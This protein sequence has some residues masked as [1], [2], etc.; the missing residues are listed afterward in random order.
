[1]NDLDIFVQLIEIKD[2]QQQQI[3]LTELVGD[4]AE[5]QKRVL[6]LLQ[7]HVKGGSF[8]ETKDHFKFPVTKPLE[9]GE[10]VGDSVGPYKL[11]EVIGEGGMGTVFVADQHVPISRRVALKIIKSGMDSRSVIARFEAERQALALMDHPN[12]ARVLD[13]GRTASGSPYFC[14]EL[15]KGIAITEY[16]EKFDLSVSDRLRL[17]IPICNAIQHAHQKGII[18][19]D[20]KPSNILVARHDGVAVPKVID[21]GVAKAIGQRLTEGTIYTQFGQIIGTLEYMSPEQAEFNQLDIDTRTDVYSLGVVLYQLLTGVTPIDGK[22]LRSAAFD[23]LLRIIREEVPMRPSWKVTSTLTASK[24]ANGKPIKS[25]HSVS[26]L[27]NELD[28]IIMKTLEKDRSRRYDSPSDLAKDLAN[29]LSG[30]PVNAHPPSRIYQFRKLLNRNKA[31]SLAMS[32]V[33]LSLLGGVLISGRETARAVKAE[34]R[35]RSY[36][37][38]VEYASQE[39]QQQLKIKNA[40]TSFLLDDLL[41]KAATSNQELDKY[42]PTPDL[43]VVEALSR[44]ATHVEARF[45][46]DPKTECEIRRVL[47][48]AFWNIGQYDKSLVQYELAMEIY[49]KLAVKNNTT[50]LQLASALVSSYLRKRDLKKAESMLDRLGVAVEHRDESDTF[51]LEHKMHLAELYLRQGKIV[52]ANNI[53]EKWLAYAKGKFGETGKWTRR[54]Q[55]KLGLAKSSGGVELL[56]DVYESY[57]DQFGATDPR[58][59]HP[60]M[61]LAEKYK[62]LG[63]H[64]KSAELY[65]Q[66]LPLQIKFQGPHHANTLNAMVWLSDNLFEIGR[67]DESLEYLH[68][69]YNIERNPSHASHDTEP[70]LGIVQYALRLKAA[71]REKEALSLL[72][73]WNTEKTL[74]EVPKG[75]ERFIIAREYAYALDESDHSQQAIDHLEEVYSRL[76]EEDDPHQYWKALFLIDIGVFN[77]TLQNRIE[78]EACLNK[79]MHILANVDNVSNKTFNACVYQSAVLGVRLGYYESSFAVLEKQARKCQSSLGVNNILTVHWNELLASLFFKVGRKSDAFAIMEEVLEGNRNVFGN[80]HSSTIKSMVLVAN[81][82]L[83]KGC[84]DRAE[85]LLREA[86]LATSESVGSQHPRTLGIWTERA[87]ILLDK[88]LPEQVIEQAKEEQI[89]FDSIPEWGAHIRRGFN[90]VLIE[91]YLREKQYSEAEERLTPLLNDSQLKAEERVVPLAWAAVIKSKLGT[92]DEAIKAIEDARECEK[93]LYLG[94]P[95]INASLAF[96]TGCVLLNL[97]R[98]AD[99]IP[100]LR[101][102]FD[103]EKKFSGPRRI[104][105]CSEP[106][107]EALRSLGKREEAEQ[108]ELEIS[109]LQSPSCT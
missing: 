71:C 51:F 80:A 109:A 55:R 66:L 47:G 25:S 107:I 12:I 44:A 30:N 86:S 28:W 77:A 4:D 92:P 82:L 75:D 46:D 20:I 29:Y 35:A 23:E 106:L 38:S 10:R 101:T 1:M 84:D 108:L 97:K 6:D 94:K 83:E 89:K 73:Q 17:F 39:L 74:R 19:R 40:V 67:V 22:R 31:A 79:G 78:A 5:L 54:F 3:R 36:A 18:H 68:K 95:P 37:K 45:H 104:K 63:L 59:V 11:L 42:E 100:Y 87:R 91:A 65:K 15:V 76:S 62:L 9:V 93:S 13:A 26:L 98:Y 61:N 41:K 102:A 24:T 105:R 90:L 56:Q 64:L 85:Q 7:A 49:D 58:S 33:A 32:A 27:R 14:M 69:V 43:T 88:D 16:C 60:G 53:L 50:M 70:Q 57:K 96:N 99:S 34:S 103:E 21:F 72:Q 52:A 2:I 48:Q 8:L 81:L